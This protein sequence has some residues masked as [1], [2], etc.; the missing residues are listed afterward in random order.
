MMHYQQGEVEKWRRTRAVTFLMA[1][2]WGD[3]KTVPG[4]ATEFMPLPGDPPGFDLETFDI[5]GEFAKLRAQG[6]NV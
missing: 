5:E 6:H 3:P 2:M 1:R 4:S